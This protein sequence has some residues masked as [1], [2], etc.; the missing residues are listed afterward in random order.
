MIYHYTNING[1]NGILES[2]CLWLVS[3]Q[4]MSDITDRFYGNLFATVALLQSNDEDVKLLR[5]NLTMQDIMDINMQ[6]FQVD[7]YSA[8]FCSKSDND[9]LWINYADSNK[10]V[11]LAFDDSFLRSHMNGIIADNLERIDEDDELTKSDKD[12]LIPRKV[13]YGYPIDFFIKV[14]KDMKKLTIGEYNSTCQ[15]FRTKQLYKDWLLFSLIIMAGVVKDTIFREEDEIRLLFQNRYSDEYVK[16]SCIYAL[17][18]MRKGKIFELLGIDK[19]IKD[20]KNRRM[21][22]NLSKA[23]VSALIPTIIVGDAFEE[24]IEK[25]K[26]KIKT[27]GLTETK[28]LNRKGEEL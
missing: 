3:S 19:E 25:L 9:Y 26:N 27:S 16:R 21:E 13:K 8:S 18:K 11:C 2:K 24:N 12:L 15:D 6:T 20:E 4:S 1:L 14:V 5:D 23:F 22:L 7:F 28:I 17:E 10:G